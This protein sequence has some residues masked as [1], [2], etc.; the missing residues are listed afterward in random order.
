MWAP[1]PEGFGD[2]ET[3]AAHA[4]RYVRR[5]APRADDTHVTI[6]CAARYVRRVVDHAM[7]VELSRLCAG[8]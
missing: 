1:D 2:M 5:V 7:G 6:T 3:K 4:A 8:T